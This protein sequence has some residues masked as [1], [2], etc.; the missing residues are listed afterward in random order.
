L[1]D[2]L[3]PRT[4]SYLRRKYKSFLVWRNENL[5][6]RKYVLLLSVL[7]GFGSGLSAV[8]I[9]NAVHSI[10]SLVELSLFRDYHNFLYFLLPLIGIVIT[11]L[12]IRYVIKEPIGH[13]IPSTL[14]AISKK[15]ARIPAKRIWTSIVTSAFTVGFGGSTGLEGPTVATSAALGSNLG[16]IGRVN[17]RV[18]ALLIGCAA[19]GAMASIFQAP[20]A[21]IVFALEVFMLDLTMWSLI[22]LFMAAISA[23]LTSKFFMGDLI[24]FPVDI[25]ESFSLVQFPFFIV[26]GICT[27]LVS[28]YFSNTY[29]G[30]SKRFG[31]IKKPMH[32]ALVGGTALGILIFFLPPLYGEGYDTINALINDRPSGIL[33]RSPFVGYSDQI[34]VVLAFI[35]ALVFLKIVATTI[36]F[37]SGG[38]GGI[39]APTLFMGSAVG[40]VFAKGINLMGFVDL[41]VS[42][43]SLVAMAGLMAG[44]LHAPL[45]AMFLIAEITGGYELFI[46]L[47]ITV[48]ISYTTSKVFLS[49][50]I[51]TQALAR[52]GALLTHHAD[53]NVLSL[54]RVSDLTERHFIELNPDWKLGKLVE[55]ISK[56]KRNIFPVVDEEEK[57]LGIVFLDEIRD[58]LFEQE[59][60]DKIKVLDIMTSP[61]AVI[62][63]GEPVGDVVDK[64]EKTNAWLLPVIKEH[65]F[66]GFVSKS[67][68]FSAYRKMLVEFSED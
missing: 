39:F 55:L 21:S 54:L 53:K 26:L 16:R 10:E 64:F 52:K 44:V 30:L 32:K 68:L 45:M 12:I 7:V 1:V 56:S 37:S 41:P 67:R 22:P 43:F 36:T 40:F 57:L 34:L 14:F 50:T 3:G 27:G 48:A 17:F 49:H 9:K 31:R 38:V 20:V 61:P 63:Y 5:D 46:P 65:R 24:L 2:V 29:F 18:R 66:F 4:K 42:N 59:K 15:K 51:Y 6:Q 23:V 47:M 19:T 33:D 13:G 8:V 60:Y 25:T 35:V 58:I 28:L 11:V 62:Q